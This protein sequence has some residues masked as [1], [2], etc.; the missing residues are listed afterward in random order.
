MLYTCN[1]IYLKH[2]SSVCLCIFIILWYALCPAHKEQVCLHGIRL[3]HK[4]GHR[5][6]TDTKTGA[7][8]KSGHRGATD[9]KTGA[10]PK[11]GHWGATDT[12]TGAGPKSGHRGATDTKTGAGPKSGHQGATDTKTGAGPKSGHQGATDTKTGAGPK[13]GHQGATDTKTGA[14]PKSGHQGATDTKTGAGP[15]S[16]HQGATDTKTGAGPKS[17]HRGATDT[18]TGAGPKP[19]SDWVCSAISAC[20]TLSDSVCYDSHKFHASRPGFLNLPSHL[21]MYN[22]MWAALSPTVQSRAWFASILLLGAGWP[23]M[24]NKFNIHSKTELSPGI[25]VSVNVPSH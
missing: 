2:N 18:K 6:A 11:S 3:L 9:T 25:F 7:G 15:K 14:G 1:I 12:K 16:G 22:G 10:G 24:C 5:G 23:Y 21:M 8:P 4:S 17:G 13:S 20:L 19:G